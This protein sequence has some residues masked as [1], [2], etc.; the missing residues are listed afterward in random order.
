MDLFEDPG[1]AAHWRPKTRHTVMTNY[2]LWL[3]WLKERGDLDPTKSPAERATKPRISAY[4]DDLRARGL[5]PITISNRITNLREALRV[6]EPG[7]DLSFLD[8]VMV[9]VNAAATPVRPKRPR[10]VSPRDLLEGAIREM[11]RL[12]AARR[13]PHS[14]RTAERYRDALIIA[15]L[16]TRPLRIA[17]LAAIELGRHLRKVEETYWCSFDGSEMKD[18]QPLEFPVPRFLTVWFDRYLDR[19]RPL[20]LR[21]SDSPRLWITIRATPMVENTIYCRVTA[22]TK[23]LFDRRIN[24]H[25]FRDCVAT[26]IAEEA[27]EQVNIIARILGHETL[28]TSE[29]HYNQAGTR[30]A[31]E[32]YLEVLERACGARCL[33]MNEACA[34]IEPRRKA[35]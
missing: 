23:H 2:G 7:V 19:H 35:P 6:M 16:A 13:S 26:F 25:L 20:L 9:R 27:P 28:K 32:R 10:M 24:P 17:N 18:R 22:T 31:Q 30:R 11:S 1:L 33:T 12:D 14:R 5:A 3:A 21:D 15:F 4:L 8:H 34:E 29:E